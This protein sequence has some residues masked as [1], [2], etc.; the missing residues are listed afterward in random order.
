MGSS[1]FRPIDTRLEGISEVEGIRESLLGRLGTIVGARVPLAIVG[2]AE[3]GGNDG[4]FRLKVVG[5]SVSFG[6][7][8]IVGWLDGMAD[9]LLGRTDGSPVAMVDI[10]DG[11]LVGT[12][13]G[14][15]ITNGGD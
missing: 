1:P 9:V 12:V 15:E 3:D 13:D 8:G 2:K 7:A 5:E 11:A 14:S 10:P 6:T 4:L